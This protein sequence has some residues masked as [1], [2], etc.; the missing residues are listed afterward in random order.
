M[1]LESVI[2]SMKSTSVTEKE[3]GVTCKCTRKCATMSCP[4]KKSLQL[5][6]VKCHPSNIKCTNR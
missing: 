6:D 1:D 5:C 2:E 4:C 3:P